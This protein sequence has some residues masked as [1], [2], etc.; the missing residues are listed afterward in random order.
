MKSSGT[1]AVTT[2]SA[3][4]VTLVD[5]AGTTY[6]RVRIVNEGAVAGF[7]SVN[8]TDWARL[9]ASSSIDVDVEPCSQILQV[10]RD[11]SSN[12]ASVYGD[13]RWVERRL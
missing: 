10:K 3:A 1:T 8:G 9:S 4:A 13:V 11:G 2:S 6:N 12:L 7:W 5:P